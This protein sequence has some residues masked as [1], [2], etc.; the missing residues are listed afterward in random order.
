MPKIP[1][2]MPVVKFRRNTSP[3]ASEV[4]AIKKYDFFIDINI[5]FTLII[6]FFCSNIFAVAT[7]HCASNAYAYIM[8]KLLLNY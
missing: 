3:G 6:L 8:Y 7:S 4:D 1:N 5:Y 2:C